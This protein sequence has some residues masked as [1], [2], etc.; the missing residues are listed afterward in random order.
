MKSGFHVGDHIVEIGG[1]IIYLVLHA[2]KN[3]YHLKPI[4]FRYMNKVF[5]KERAEGNC[6]LVSDIEDEDEEKS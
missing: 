3:E 6:V 1:E 4:N 2:W 5:T